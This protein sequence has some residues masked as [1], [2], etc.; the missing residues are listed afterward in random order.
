MVRSVSSRL[1]LGEH[2]LQVL[3][4]GRLGEAR[5]LALSA[6]ER[7]ELALDPRHVGVLRHLEAGLAL[8]GDAAAHRR[9]E[10]REE[11]R[12]AHAE[13]ARAAR[14]L[15]QLQRASGEAVEH[16][17]AV[18]L[19]RGLLLRGVYVAAARAVQEVDE[20][21]LAITRREQASGCKVHAWW[22]VHGVMVCAVCVMVCAW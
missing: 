19:A 5:E 11:P 12:R 18:L 10:Q 22:C 21:G 3:F 14:P 16:D 8:G 4:G 17:A 6:L 9:R 1:E 7:V 20:L 15:A 2:E 13:L